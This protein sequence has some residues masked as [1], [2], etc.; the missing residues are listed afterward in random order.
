MVGTV[1]PTFMMNFGGKRPIFW[2]FFAKFWITHACLWKICRKGDPCLENFEPIP[3]GCL[4]HLSEG[5]HVPF[6]RV[7]FSSIFF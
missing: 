5:D 2:L 4:L 3:G 7:S 1:Q 6:F